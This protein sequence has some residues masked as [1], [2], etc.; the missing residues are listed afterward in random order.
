MSIIESSKKHLDRSWEGATVPIFGA[1]FLAGHRHY[2]A[3]RTKSGQMGNAAAKGGHIKSIGNDKMKRV[4]FGNKVAK[5]PLTVFECSAVRTAA[6]RRL[7]PRTSKIIF[8]KIVGWRSAPASTRILPNE[9]REMKLS[10][11]KV[12]NV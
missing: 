7:P 6:P 4:L 11:A 12:G 2:I 3:E 9:R 5:G 8:F 1:I 10:R